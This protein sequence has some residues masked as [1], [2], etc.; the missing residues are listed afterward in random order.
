MIRV[1]DT[2][3][4]LLR[5]ICEVFLWAN[6][7][8]IFVIVFQVIARYFFS[9]TSTALEELQ[10]HLYSVAMLTGIAYAI[11]SGS[12]VRAD[13]LFNRFSEKWKNIIEMLTVLVFI[14][15]FFSFIFY[16]SLAFVAHSYAVSEASNSPGGLSCRWLIKG[17]IPLACC[18]INLA[19]ISKLFRTI[20]KM[21]RR[22]DVS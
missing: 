4:K 10:W 12:H 17:V 15:P 16:H 2:I 1:A 9:W 8:L 19:A 22:K 5:R 18:M 20:G 6:F 11:T 3:D 13:I 14:L 7:I 21:R